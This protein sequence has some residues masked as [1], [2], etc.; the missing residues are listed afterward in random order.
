[1]RTAQVGSRPSDQG[2][3]ANGAWKLSPNRTPLVPEPTLILAL[4]IRLRLPADAVVD[5]PVSHFAEAGAQ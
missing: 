5:Q 1:M 2:I 4:N 3:G